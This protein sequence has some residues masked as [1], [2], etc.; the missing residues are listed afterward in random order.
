M[1]AQDDVKELDL[2]DLVPF[3]SMALHEATLV[4]AGWILCHGHGY[5][6]AG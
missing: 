5:L 4:H 3:A 1:G 6:P 2:D